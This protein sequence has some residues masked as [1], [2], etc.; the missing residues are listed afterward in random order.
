MLCDVSK[1][2]SHGIYKSNKNTELSPLWTN[3][4]TLPLCHNKSEDMLTVLLMPSMWQSWTGCMY[5]DLW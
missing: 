3:S 2:C 4:V 5:I 1:H